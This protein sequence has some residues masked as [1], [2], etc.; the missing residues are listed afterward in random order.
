L[1]DLPPELGVNGRP[2]P[3]HG[4]QLTHH[5]L[6]ALHPSDV[7][8][9][10]EQLSAPD[11]ATIMEALD[12]E[13]AAETLGEMEPDMQADVLEDLPTKAAVSIL[14]ELP[15]DEAADVLA[16]LT[17]ERANELLKGL[18]PEDAEAVR[19][20]M[21]YPEDVAGG[22]M[23][24]DYVAL[25]AS[26]TAQQTIDSLRKLAP[27]AEEVYY[28]YVVDDNERLLG[29][30]SLRDLIV[31]PPDAKLA[32]IVKDAG[33]AVSVPADMERDEVVRVVE[34]YNLLALPVVDEEERLVGVITVDDALA[35]AVPE[36]RRW[37][38][39]LHR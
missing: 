19:E 10:V 24:N 5:K 37:L 16:D 2:T 31:A 11:R 21:A 26:Q 25:S 13:T 34:K 39:R 14:A 27:P 33:E 17:E 29:V 35:A 9:L 12:A 30:L 20:L 3:K 38:P 32:A 6:A 22:M 23:T 8:D 18:S 1:A 7:A 28:L 4:L 36:E 15:P